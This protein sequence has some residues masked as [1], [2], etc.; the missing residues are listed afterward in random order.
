MTTTFAPDAREL[1][2]RSSDGMHVILLWHPRRDAVSV[3]VGDSRTGEVYDIPVERE[4]ALD[5][6]HHPFAYAA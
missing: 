2:S 3:T 6:F 5:A 1:A 4:R